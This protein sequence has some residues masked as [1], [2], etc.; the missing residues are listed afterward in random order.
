[1]EVVFIKE[2]DRKDKGLEVIDLVIY[3]KQKIMTNNNLWFN[4]EGGCGPGGVM[5][6]G[7]RCPLD[8]EEMAGGYVRKCHCEIIGN[9]DFSCCRCSRVKPDWGR[10]TDT[11]DES[12][13][14]SQPYMASLTASSPSLGP[15]AGM[16]GMD[17]RLTNGNSYR[18]MDGATPF[19]GE[20]GSE[21]EIETWE[22][23]LEAVP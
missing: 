15:A 5:C 12:G 16:I 1:M 21:T 17:G 22:E 10:M 9:N 18:G 4:A 20:T 6:E 2:E 19:V 13:S 14:E 23:F 8:G 11:W 7:G 3:K